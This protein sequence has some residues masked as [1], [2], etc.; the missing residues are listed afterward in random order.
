MTDL[1]LSF[2][3]FSMHLFLFQ[4]S[5]LPIPCLIN[6]N[7][8][9]PQKVVDSRDIF[10]SEGQDGDLIGDKTYAIID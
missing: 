10:P 4:F 2:F 3:C 9:S 5:M 6:K 7:Q 8:I 1:H